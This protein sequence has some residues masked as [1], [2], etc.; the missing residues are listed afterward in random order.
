MNSQTTEMLYQELHTGLRSFVARRVSSPDDAEDILQEVFARIH[1]HS[2]ELAHVD[3]VSGWVFRVARN[4]ITDHHRAKGAAARATARFAQEPS[5]QRN[6]SAEQVDA[7]ES[8]SECVRSFVAM[9]SDEYREALI[10]TE[11]E[12]MSQKEAAEKVGLSVSGMK[13]RIQRGRA[14]LGGLF[15]ACCV[16]EQDVRNRIIDYT[17]RN[18]CECAEEEAAEEEIARSG[19]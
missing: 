10:L 8:L 15:R 14:K 5:H 13:S 12:G 6:E 17:E 3:S 11:R 7:T 19:A 16:I 9:L 4:A 2:A 1:L 18:P